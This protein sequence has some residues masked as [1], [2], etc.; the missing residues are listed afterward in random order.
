MSALSRVDIPA[1]ERVPFYL[2]MDEFQNIATDSIATI[3]SEARKYQLS[4]NV[5]H[6]YIDQ[7]QDSIRDAVFGNVGS[8]AAYRVSSKDAEVL[9]EMYA[10]AF[11][12]RDIM[13]VDNY[14]YFAK[15]LANGQPVKPF[16]VSALPPT[17]GIKGQV[18]KLKKISYLKYGRDRDTVES[19]IMEKY[20]SL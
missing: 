9:S 10:P 15:I 20:K 13:N 18:E 6:Q 3:L 5:V 16:S 11:S 12:Q 17:E 8:M 14:N 1:E 2:Y 7:L 4:L 19:E